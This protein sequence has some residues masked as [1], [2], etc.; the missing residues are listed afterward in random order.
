MPNKAPYLTHFKG[1]VALKEK[2]SQLSLDKIS[3]VLEASKELSE[4]IVLDKSAKMLYVNGSIDNSTE[5]VEKFFDK[6]AKVIQDGVR[7]EVKGDDVAD[8][9]DL[10]FKEQLLYI[11]SYRLTKGKL[12]RYSA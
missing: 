8:R 7:V 10:V 4:V 3:N 12:T 6:V 5:L 1:D 9:Y 11:Q 2:T